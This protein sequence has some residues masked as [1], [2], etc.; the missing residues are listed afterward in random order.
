[1]KKGKFLQIGSGSRSKSVAR[2]EDAARRSRK[3]ADKRGAL[4]EA[5]RER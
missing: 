5:S 4:R 2:A 1:M 3:Q